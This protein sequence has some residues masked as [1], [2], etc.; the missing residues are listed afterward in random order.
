VTN[1]DLTCDCVFPCIQQ[2]REEN[3]KS[4]SI[5]WLL[6]TLGLMMLASTEALA[7]GVGKEGSRTI[8]AA[9][10]LPA[11]GARERASD[12][13]NSRPADGRCKIV[14]RRS[15]AWHDGL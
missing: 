8:A 1:F 15:C 11:R 2:D 7:V 3:M 9:S 6:V 5:F 14:A 13:A 12:A 4:K 10:P